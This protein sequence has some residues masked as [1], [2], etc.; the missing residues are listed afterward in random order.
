MQAYKPKLMRAQ[1][2][3]QE[4]QGKAE[5]LVL[6]DRRVV[7][8]KGPDDQPFEVVERQLGPIVALEGPKPGAATREEEEEGSGHR[9]QHEQ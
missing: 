3:R 4:E 1:R 2:R 8:G 9:V 7:E 6:L 5:E